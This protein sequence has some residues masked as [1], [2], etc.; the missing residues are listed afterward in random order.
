MILVKRMTCTHLNALSVL[1]TVLE[2]PEN[3]ICLEIHNKVGTASKDTERAV[4]AGLVCVFAHGKGLC[5]QCV[6]W[7]AMFHRV[8]GQVTY[9]V[10]GFSTDRV[11]LLIQEGLEEDALDRGEGLIGDTIVEGYAQGFRARTWGGAK[12]EASE[13][14]KRE[15]AHLGYGFQGRRYE[16]GC[17]LTLEG[18]EEAV[19]NRVEG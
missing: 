7:P 18:V 12:E 6:P 10:D 9:R 8:V 11:D 4:A 17:I 5:L 14:Y 13:E 1:Q 16:I 15:E 3:R 19:L 2:D